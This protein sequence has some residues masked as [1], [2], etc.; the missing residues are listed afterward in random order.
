[1]NRWTFH[2][3]IEMVIFLPD[4]GKPEITRA[5]MGAMRSPEG[6]PRAGARPGAERVLGHAPLGLRPR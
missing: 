5:G 4:T 6:P 1:M 3:G 2:C